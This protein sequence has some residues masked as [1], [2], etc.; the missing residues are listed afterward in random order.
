MKP[1]K[2]AALIAALAL[3]IPMAMVRKS[4]LCTSFAD[5]SRLAPI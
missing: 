2:I 1:R 4:R 5:V 3:A